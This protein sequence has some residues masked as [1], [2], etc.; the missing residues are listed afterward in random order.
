MSGEFGAL[1]A[2]VLGAWERAGSWPGFP[3]GGARQ[4][5]GACS[6]GAGREGG[7]G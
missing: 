2:G 7:H 6:R 1:A 4:L 5:S 3:T